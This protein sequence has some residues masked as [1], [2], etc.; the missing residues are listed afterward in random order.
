MYLF[1]DTE[2][3][4]LPRN[5]KAPVQ[6]VNNWPRMVQ[7]AWL[8]YEDSGEKISG[9]NFIIKPEG[10]SIPADASGVHGISTEKAISEGH[11]LEEVLKLFAEQI[12]RTDT[13]VAHNISFDEKIVGAEFIRKRIKHS[14]FKKPQICTMKS[15]TDYCRLPGRYGYKWVLPVPLGPTKI[16]LDLSSIKERLKRR[17]T[18]SLSKSG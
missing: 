7:I 14:L 4:E 6:D 18:D 5:W 15:S 12:E 10:Y 2:T 16:T 3:T 8:L 17:K 9:E 13:L 1:F 11:D